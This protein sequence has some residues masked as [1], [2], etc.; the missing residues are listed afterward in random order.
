MRC[1]ECGSRVWQAGD[2]VPAGTYVRVDNTSYKVIDLRESAQLPPSFDGH[3]ALYRDAAAVCSCRASLVQLASAP[4]SA[5][6]A[7]ALVA[8]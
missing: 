6:R 5:D 4:V 8:R 1:E 2:M 7:H 3:V